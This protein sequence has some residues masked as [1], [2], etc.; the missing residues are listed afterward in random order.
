MENLDL[1]DKRTVKIVPKK[2]KTK[3]V[4]FKPKQVAKETT[5]SKTVMDAPPPVVKVDMKKQKKQK[6][7]KTHIPAQKEE[8]N[9]KPETAKPVI[10][11][12]NVDIIDE[13]YTMQSDVDMFD[14][15]YDNYNFQNFSNNGMQ[16][17]EGTFQN[18]TGDGF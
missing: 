3:K 1:E 5:I 15:I 17:F 7:E 8:S 9:P 12:S 2:K 11:E 14:E 4:E 13:R 16:V 6:K 18:P 10:N